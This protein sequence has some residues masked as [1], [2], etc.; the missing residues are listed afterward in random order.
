MALFGTG[1]GR[2]ENTGSG[3]DPK[4]PDPDPTLKKT[5]SLSDLIFSN[6]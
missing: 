5:G 4:K 3:S 2:Q 6:I 1:F